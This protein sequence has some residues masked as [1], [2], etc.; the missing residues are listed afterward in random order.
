MKVPLCYPVVDEEMEAAAINALRNEKMVLGESVF[1]FEQEFAAYCG[2]KRAVSVSSG[3]NAL[4]IVMEALG[5]RGKEVVTTP[6]SFIA[7]GNAIVHAGAT[8]KFADIA[9]DWNLDPAK[10]PGA[11]GENTA[12]LL[13]VHL[14]GY[15]ARMRELLEVAGEK[16]IPVV[17]DA[18]E[19]HG[20]EYFGKRAGALGTAGC[21]S[22]Y[23]TKNMTVGGDGGVITTDDEA[24]ADLCAKM[25]DCGRVDHYTHDVVG[26]TSRLNS[27]NAAIARVQLKRLDGWNEIRRNIAS[28]YREGLSGIEGLALPPVEGEGVKAV[29]YMFVVRTPKRDALAA[30]LKENAIGTGIHFPVPIHVQPVYKQMYGYAGGEFPEAER[31]GDEVLSLPIFAE[32]SEEQARYVVENVVEFFSKE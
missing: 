20:A 23:S 16:G 32:M 24:L 11:M 15:P 6:M 14:Y 3:T 4:S 1:K 22:F 25:R 21:F 26:Y 19:A 27:V 5:A 18:A 9:G 31:H 12:A 30:F 10:V 28:I 13:P 2:T 7:T 8:P 29:Y 17:E